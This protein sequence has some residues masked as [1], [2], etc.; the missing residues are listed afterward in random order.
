MFRTLRLLA[1][2]QSDHPSDRFR[3][4]PVLE[5]LTDGDRLVLEVTTGTG[6][7]QT[8]LPV[9][10][11][12]ALADRIL[13]IIDGKDRITMM[14]VKAGVLTIEGGFLHLR[15]ANRGDPY[16]KGIQFTLTEAMPADD[17]GVDGPSVFVDDGDLRYFV[18]T[19]RKL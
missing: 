14:R 7:I 12:G 13:A 4:G 3:D 6:R 5:V 9:G 8:G 2:L 18:S 10:D 1:R 11:A 16:A 15:D 19:L 17:W